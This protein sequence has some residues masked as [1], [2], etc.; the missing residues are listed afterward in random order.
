[1][2]LFKK[3]ISSLSILCAVGCSNNNDEQ[4]R[5]DLL[6][7]L[8]FHIAQISQQL[9]DDIEKEKQGLYPHAGKNDY[10]SK[11]AIE[12]VLSEKNGQRLEVSERSLLSLNHIKN[13]EGYR[14]L[15]AKAAEL[16]VKVKIDVII[17]DGDEIESSEELDEYIDDEHRYFVIS[18]YG[19]AVSP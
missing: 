7:W 4:E 17:I 5:K 8:D 15:V 16:N 1:M 11:G 13:T 9:Q 6:K 18:V 3:L 10:A 19:W 2:S 12:Y 14:Q